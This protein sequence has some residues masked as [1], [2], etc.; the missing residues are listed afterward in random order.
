VAEVLA[1][2]DVMSEATRALARPNAAHD[3]ARA[4]LAGDAR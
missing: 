3:I 1:R 4:M 2:R